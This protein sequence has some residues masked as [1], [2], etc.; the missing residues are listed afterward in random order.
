MKNLLPKENLILWLF[1][2]HKS[3]IKYVGLSNSKP[4][5]IPFDSV[6]VRILDYLS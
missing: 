2:W 3:H 1:N 6:A 4:E 5:R